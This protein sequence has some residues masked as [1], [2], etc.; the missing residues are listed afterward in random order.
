M[1]LVGNGRLITHNPEVPYLDKGCVAFEGNAIAD[2]GK[3]SDLVERYPGSSFYN[4]RGRVIM[5]GLTNAHTHIYSA[6]AR[7]FNLPQKKPN[8]TFLQILENVWW[9]LDKVLDTDDSLYS[10]YATGIECI[11]NGVTTI[12]DHHASQFHI[13]GSL[14]AIE[15]ALSNLGLRACL[16]YE[17]TDRDGSEKTDEAIA[18]NISYIDHAASSSMFRGM[19]GMHASFTLSQ[20]TIE[21]C[22]DAMGDRDAGFHI[23]CAEGPEDQADCL[24]KHGKRV[25]ERL[26]DSGVLGRKTIAVHNIHASDTEISI[27]KDTNTMAVHNPESNMGNAVGCAR[28][29]DM[30]SSGVTLG[31][32]TDAYASDMFES[33]KVANLIHKHELKDPGVAFS[34][35]VGM[36]FKGNT[37]ICSRF[38][39]NPIGVIAKGASADVI[40]VDYTP[41]TPMDETNCY[42]HIMFG[43]SGKCVDTVFIGGSCV[44][45]D[46]VLITV[47]ED[48][49]LSRSREQAADFWKRVVG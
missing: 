27:L 38:F 18:E 17:T 49:I 12:F 20:E 10:A 8:K 15:K 2:F 32:G 16:C 29:L 37:E 41:H 1:Q 9:R 39:P 30:V 6:F 48:G 23:H 19:L 26:R 46:R 24:E 36:L 11:R 34:E 21:K 4:A 43:I 42:G 7:G 28:V 45:K 31:L 22:V 13:P 25:L 14:M 40:V 3:T 44:M 33:L 47:D 5:P 35:S